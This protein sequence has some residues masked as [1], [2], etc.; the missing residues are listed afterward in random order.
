MVFHDYMRPSV[1]LAGLMKQPVVYIY[2]HDSVYLGED[3]PTH[4]PVEHLMA[5]RGIPNLWVIRPAD[6]IETLEA[7]QV[8]LDRRDGPVALCLTRHGLPSLDR[9]PVASEA[10]LAKVL[11]VGRQP[12]RSR[13]CPDGFGQ[14]S[15]HGPRGPGSPY[16]GRYWRSSG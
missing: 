8:A 14:R 11:R 9:S 6:A 13:C 10:G 16:A 12:R 4:Q 5:M 3:G 1:R 7:W 15:V 2:T